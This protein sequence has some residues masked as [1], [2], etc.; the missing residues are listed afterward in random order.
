MLLWLLWMNRESWQMRLRRPSQIQWTLV[1][2]LMRSGF[3]DSYPIAVILIVII[4]RVTR[5]AGGAGSGSTKRPVEQSGSCTS[6]Q[7]RRNKQS[8]RWWVMSYQHVEACWSL[9]VYSFSTTSNR[10]RR[11]RGSTQ[12]TSSRAG[13]AHVVSTHVYLG[14]ISISCYTSLPP[15]SICHVLIQPTT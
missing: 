10:R 4:G 6:L 11:R 2:M 15:G 13:D 5:R 9:W 7:P 3:Y 14:I 8:G 1:S 12:A